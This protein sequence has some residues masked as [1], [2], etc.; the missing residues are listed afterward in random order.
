M[1]KKPVILLDVQ[2]LRADF[3]ILAQEIMPGIPLVYLDNAA[4]TQKPDAVINA[5][6]NYYRRDNA[7]IHRGIHTLAERATAGYEN[8][9]KKVADFI[10]AGSVK[11][12]VFV[13]NATEGINLVAWSWGR[14]NVNAGDEIL[15][16][17]LEHH[18]NLVPW[19]LLAKE[20]GAMLRFLPV[21][22]DCCIDLDRLD[23]MLTEKTRLV[24]FTGMSNV[25]GAIT[26]VEQ[27]V[28]RAHA[29]GA[30]V[31]LDGA[32]LVPHTP[33]DVQDLDVD[34]MAFSGHKMCGPTGI[35]VLYGKQQL[36]E[37][38]PPIFGGGDMIRRVTLED[39]EWNDL[40]WKFEAGTPNI[41]QAIG[42]GVAVDYLSAIGMEKIETYE[43][44]IAQ[45]ALET[46]GKLDGIDLLG[47]PAAERGAVVAFAIQG[48]HPHD[49]AELLNREGI[50]VRAGHHCA[51]PLH[52]KLKLTATTRASFYFYN[53]LDEV[54]KL[55]AGL[56]RVQKFF[57]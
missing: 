53:T 32:Q 40:P 2:T 33:V 41:A 21:D 48:L 4:T 52:Q 42:L 20:K 31:L 5:I 30:L 35:G 38:M 16:T 26:P 27:V 1:V 25:L 10:H 37:S 17:E 8:A 46:L 14:G 51:M 47:P 56:A 23:N 18:S 43:H 36:L 24:A 44:Q 9:R 55:A 19:Q 12:I 57:A 50:A 28:E 15:L 11:E 45:Y 34:F 39:S 54:D 22:R 7:N 3:P 6:S 49:I 13:R 29:A